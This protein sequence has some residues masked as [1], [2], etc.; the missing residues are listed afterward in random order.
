M[1][2]PLDVSVHPDGTSVLITN[3]GSNTVSILDASTYSLITTISVGG[4][5]HAYGECVGPGV[6]RLLKEDFCAKLEALK[7]VIEQ[8]TD[9][10]GRPEYINAA[11]TSGNLSLRWYLWS[12]TGPED[13]DLRRLDA[14]LGD[15]VFWSD[16]TIVDAV[17]DAIRHGWILDVELRSKLL[18]VID[19]V[20]R[21]DRVLVA[22]AIDDAIIAVADPEKIAGA[23]EMLEKG[24]ALVKEAAVWQQ[25]D[26]KASLLF[27]AISQYRN[28][29]EAAIDLI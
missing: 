28:A 22:V 1:D 3:S 11:L 23:Q 18:A 2:A 13:V 9:G 27:D 6:P 7:S 16:E 21:A 8:S 25:L 24:D 5:P 4:N 14:F 15:M 17:I 29:W 12:A 20:I 26:K 19:E 10:V